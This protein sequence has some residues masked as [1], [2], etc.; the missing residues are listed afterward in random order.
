MKKCLLNNKYEYDVL[1][2]CLYFN[3]YTEIKSFS[4]KILFLLIY[5][6]IFAIRRFDN[7]I[8]KSY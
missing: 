4:K 7:N 3:K 5:K 2:L 8:L 6:C 1:F